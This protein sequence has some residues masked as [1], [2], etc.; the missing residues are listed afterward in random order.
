MANRNVKLVVSI[1]AMAVAI[2]FLVVSATT[3]GGY[4][5]DYYHTPSEFLPRA[6]QY[7][8]GAVRVNGSVV[9]GTARR[10]PPADGGLPVLE[11]A[12]GDSA[13]SIPV[14]YEGTTVPDAFTEGASLVVEGIYRRS[15]TLEARQLLVK[16]P[17]KYETTNS[18]GG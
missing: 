2:A 18:S 17:S 7:V 6:A 13:V 15:G 4:T 12:L 3:Q 9:R 16:C 14:R 5:T 1:G 11:F 8:D 10:M